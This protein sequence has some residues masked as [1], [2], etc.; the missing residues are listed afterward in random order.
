MGVWIRLGNSS[1]RLGSLISS[2]FWRWWLFLQLKF[3][4]KDSGYEPVEV[5]QPSPYLGLSSSWRR[6]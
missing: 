5:K 1:V 2:T 4:G 6:M 3:G